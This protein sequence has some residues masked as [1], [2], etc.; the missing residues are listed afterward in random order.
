MGFSSGPWE[1]EKAV[2][3]TRIESQDGTIAF[4]ARWHDDF[5]SEMDANIALIVAAPRMWEALR[6]AWLSHS[7]YDC[8]D[9]DINAL[10]RELPAPR[11]TH[12]D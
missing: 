4:V 6:H 11:V 9:C 8:E 5:A 7:R 2:D 12:A 3:G 1:L 10:L